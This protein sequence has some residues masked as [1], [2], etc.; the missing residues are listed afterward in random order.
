METN[1]ERSFLDKTTHPS[2]IRV[3]YTV[4]ALYTPRTLSLPAFIP[5]SPLLFIPE[6]TSQPAITRII[7]KPRVWFLL[8]LINHPCWHQ[9]GSS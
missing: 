7:A 3:Q 1:L 6:A 8:S 5:E 9:D 2:K 4:H